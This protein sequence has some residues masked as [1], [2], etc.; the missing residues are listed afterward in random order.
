MFGLSF[1]LVD[2]INSYSWA[3]SNRDVTNPMCKFF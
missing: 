2:V 3:L 1:Y